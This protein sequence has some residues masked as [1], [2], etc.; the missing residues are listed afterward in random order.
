MNKIQIPW[1]MVPTDRAQYVN[2]GEEVYP[3][4]PVVEQSHWKPHYQRGANLKGHNKLNGNPNERVKNPGPRGGAPKVE[5]GD[6]G[7]GGE[8]RSRGSGGGGGRGG[9]NRGSSSSRGRGGSNA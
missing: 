7:G 5:G 1:T 6:G 8:G 2:G 3:Y 9:G 4:S